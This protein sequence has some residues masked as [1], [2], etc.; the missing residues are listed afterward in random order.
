MTAPPDVSKTI[1]AQSRFFAPAIGVDEDPV[2][3]SVH[4]PLGA[5]LVANELAPM[6]GQVAALNCLQGISGGRTGLVR[7]LITQRPGLGYT[8]RIAGQCRTTI[9]GHVL[10]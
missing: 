9:R 10:P 6:A 7:V 5:Y 2:T 4:G 3:G 8:A 1:A